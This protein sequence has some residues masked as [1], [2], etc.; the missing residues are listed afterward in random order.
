LEKTTPLAG[1]ARHPLPGRATRAK[2]KILRRADAVYLDEI[3][4]A[5][6]YA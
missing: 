1:G 6:R 4:K 2:L 5:G 3:R